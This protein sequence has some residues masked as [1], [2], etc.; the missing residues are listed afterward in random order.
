VRFALALVGVAIAGAAAFA[1]PARSVSDA[2]YIGKDVLVLE[3]DDCRP[4]PPMDDAHLRAQGSEHY[5]RGEVL[6]AQGDYQGAV[7][8]LVAAYCIYPYYTILVDIGNTYE[9]KLE[10]AKALAYFERY[11]EKVPPDAKKS[12]TCDPDPQVEK[13]NILAHI[14]ILEKLPARIRVNT[15]PADAQITLSNT[16]GVARSRER[17]GRE[18]E[19]KGGTYE[20]KIERPG[21]HTQ[22]QTITAEIG[23]PYT[24]FVRLDP[25]KGRLH[26]RAVPVD[27][28]LYLDKKPMGQGAF[29][30]ELPGGHYQ[31]YAEAPDHLATTRELE[32]LPDRDTQV[33]FELKAQP[34]YGRK[35]LLGYGIVAA[36]VSGGLLA[37]SSNDTFFY[38]ALGAVGGLTAGFFG[39]YYGTPSDLQLGTSSLTVTGSLGGGVAGGALLATVTNK[40]DFTTL[41]PGVGAGIVVGAAV[42]YY[43]GSKTNPSAGDAA[44]INSGALWGTV[45]SSLLTLSFNGSPQISGGIVL[46]GLGVGTIGGVLLQ[47]Y[48]TISRGHAALIDASGVVGIVGGL[49]TLSV[50]ARAN[51]VSVQ[52]DE[53]TSNF[54]LGGLAAGLIIG[55]VL[56]RN[57]DEPRLAVTP[58]LGRAPT[59]GGGQTL[60]YGF[61]ATF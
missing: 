36:G 40:G 58:T 59:A 32:V 41:S 51:G 21:Y 3:I 23:Q 6:F 1:Q 15:E 27:A 11:V 61:G 35:Q 19:V 26:V 44:I 4:P 45:S 7:D 2:G 25:V 24:Y 57:L 42:A 47:R 37:G 48:F 5:Q 16:A 46:S 20:M 60:T 18:L 8:E 39:I 17:A 56:T 30:A 55:G 13:E 53:R 22:N 12:G 49:A 54:A 52:N 38:D 28:K 31:L 43:A 14:G 50:F 33:A 9:K 29:D 34:E 10:Y